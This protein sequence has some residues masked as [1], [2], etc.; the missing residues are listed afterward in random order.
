MGRACGP[1]RK[2]EQT[3]GRVRDVLTEVIRVVARVRHVLEHRPRRIREREEVRVRLREA[4]RGDLLLHDAVGERG[5]RDPDAL[6]VEVDFAGVLVQIVGNVGHVVASVR[7][8]GYQ[9]KLETHCKYTCLAS[10]VEVLLLQAREHLEELRQEAGQLRSQLVVVR[11][12]RHALTEARADWLL[13]PQYV[14]QVRPR[15]R[16]WARVSLAPLPLYRPVFLQEALEAAAAGPAVCPEDE[17]VSV[18]LVRGRP[19][20]TDVC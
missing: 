18:R 5:V 11:N 17:V 9:R 8:V 2:R 14:R 16:V 12:V 7:L 4:Q 3:R 1:A 13:D 15:V 20:P 6:Q 19:E 10:K